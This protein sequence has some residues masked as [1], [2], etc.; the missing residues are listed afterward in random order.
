MFMGRKIGK[1]KDWTPSGRL[2]FYG[3]FCSVNS[4][5]EREWQTIAAASS[6]ASGHTSRPDPRR[7]SSLGE[8]ASNTRYPFGFR[9]T[10]ADSSSASTAATATAIILGK[11][12]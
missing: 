12:H 9:N 4:Y 10:R 6:A 1:S 7:D 2:P 8:T 3:T 5:P 11:P